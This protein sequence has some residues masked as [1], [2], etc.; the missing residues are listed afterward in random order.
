MVKFKAD[1][2]KVYSATQLYFATEDA[3]A[4]IEEHFKAR[5]T[6]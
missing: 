1:D 4:D 6:I 2:G 3:W 5:F